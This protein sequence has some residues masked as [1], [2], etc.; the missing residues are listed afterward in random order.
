MNIKTTLIAAVAAAMVF[1]ASVASA[2]TVEPKTGVYVGTGLSLATS[3]EDGIDDQKGFN[4]NVGYDFGLVR[5]EGV[6]DRLSDDDLQTAMFSGVG[7]YD[8]DND[9]KLTPFVGAGLAWADLS[10]VDAGA[11]SNGLAL[12]G[13]A[14][15]TYDLSSKWDVVVQ[16]RYVVAAAEVAADD[17]NTDNDTHLFTVGLR[18]T[19]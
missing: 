19:F 6:Y 10:D 17:G 12:V 18:T 15:A 5:V 16:Y 2:E 13:S 4:F 9:S 7:Y 14:G 11:D 8:F 1:G 3:T